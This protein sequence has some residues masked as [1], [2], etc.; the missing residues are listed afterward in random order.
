MNGSHNK[1]KLMAFVFFGFFIMVG[2]YNA[3]VI[4]SES[5]ISGVDMRFVKRLDEMYGV[6]VPGRIVAA[7]VT[8]QKIKPAQKLAE[9]RPIEQSVSS[10]SSAPSNDSSPAAETPQAAVQEEL[11]LNL[12][13]VINT[14]KWPSGLKSG[15]FSGSLST[16]NGIIESLELSLAGEQVSVNLA[17]MSGNVFMY[18]GAD[19]EE[20]SGMMYQVDQHAYKVT[21]T[22]GP[23]EGTH[24][25]FAAEQTLDQQHQSDANLADNNVQPGTFGQEAQEQAPVEQVQNEQPTQEQIEQPLPDQVVQ[26]DME[27]QQAGIQAQSFNMEQDTGQQQ[28]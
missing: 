23:L 19:G 11:N 18:K 21:L 5:Q 20:Y 10:Y 24:L 7:S 6:T 27:I 28:L 15:Q 9:N 17:E 2:T 14:K 26:T 3:V 1:N 13:E 16:N 25:R 8:W 22:N 4:N 12:A